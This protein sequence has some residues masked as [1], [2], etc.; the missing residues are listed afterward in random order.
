MKRYDRAYGRTNHNIAKAKFYPLLRR[1]GPSGLDMADV[2][3][4]CE[5][6]CRGA[7]QRRETGI[8]IIGGD[9]AARG[10][11]ACEHRMHARVGQGAR[12]RGNYATD[13]FHQSTTA[14]AASDANQANDHDGR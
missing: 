11:N 5:V 3:P 13:N 6:T 12:F 7:R 4:N 9:H 2:V 1:N 14:T 10:E 8:E